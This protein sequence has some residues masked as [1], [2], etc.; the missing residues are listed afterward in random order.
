MT[1]TLRIAFVALLWF[2]SIGTAA[3]DCLHNGRSYPEGT[4][5]GDRVCSNGSWVQRR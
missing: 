3:A 1:N 2:A 4:A 5:V